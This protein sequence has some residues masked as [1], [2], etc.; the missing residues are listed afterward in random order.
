MENKDG[1]DEEKTLI[2]CN[3]V[4]ELMLRL[5]EDRGLEQNKT[6]AKLSLDKGRGSVKVTHSLMEKEERVKTGQQ[7]YTNGVGGKAHDLGYFRN[8]FSL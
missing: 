1:E 4:S 5:L 8:I 6:D 3:D 2:Y 7:T